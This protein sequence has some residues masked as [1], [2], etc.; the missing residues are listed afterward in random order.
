M[1]KMDLTGNFEMYPNKNDMKQDKQQKYISIQI[2]VKLRSQSW[3]WPEVQYVTKWN[4]KLEGVSFIV[5]K[6]VA[7]NP[8]Q[9]HPN[10]NP[11]LKKYKKYVI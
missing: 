5:W 1:F 6:K 3:N 8:L 4:I 2:Y 10:F 11:R 9:I 7:R